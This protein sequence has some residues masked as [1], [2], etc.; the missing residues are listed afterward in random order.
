VPSTAPCEGSLPTRSTVGSAPPASSQKN[1]GGVCATPV[2]LDD[3]YIIWQR[4]EDAKLVEVILV[5]YLP[6]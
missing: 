1:I 5:N 2:G 3:W 4:G 6:L